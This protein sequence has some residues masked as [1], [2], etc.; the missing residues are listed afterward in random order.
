MDQAV[1]AYEC[2]LVEASDG[3]GA[4]EA[5]WSRLHAAAGTGYLSESFEWARLCRETSAGD[6]R[7]SLVC[8]VLRN[9]GRLVALLPLLVSRTAMCRVAKPLASPTNEYCP[10]L[11]DR[12]VDAPRLWQA[13]RTELGQRRNVDALVLTHVR[14]DSVLGLSLKDCPAAT[15]I[16]SLPAPYVRSSDF[17]DWQT[18][19]EQLPHR[20]QSNLRRNWKRIR[21]LGEVEFE[22]LTDRREMQDAWRWMILHKRRWLARKR[23]ASPWISSDDYFRFVEAT[24][25]IRGAAGRRSILAL[26]LDGRLIAAELVSLDRRRVEM[27]VVAYDPD[28]ARF[29]PGNLLRSEVVRWAFAQG[30][31]YDL[32]IGGDAY[33]SDW[34]NDSVDAATFVLA[35]NARGRSFAAYA[36]VRQGIARRTPEAVRARIRSLLHLPARRRR[37]LE[38]PYSQDPAS[39]PPQS[40]C[41]RP[42]SPPVTPSD[43]CGAELSPCGGGAS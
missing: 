9:H 33:K 11:F 37:M 13:L 28:Y 3:F 17:G 34:S 36:A 20:V 38:P 18:Y 40:K 21:R 43:G 30:L 25:D 31:D 41:A 1:R 4:L 39:P 14:S 8:L 10:L 15:W 23:L 26:K 5:E 27:F 24:F 7:S 32:R 42:L 12:S 2:A 22:E 29:A 6:R 16:S 19:L 35:L